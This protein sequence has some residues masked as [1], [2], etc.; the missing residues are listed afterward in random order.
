M[1]IAGIRSNRGDGYQTLVAFGWV[2]T[3]LSDP[4]YEWIEIDSVSLLVDDVVVGKTDGTL[5]CCQCKKNQIDFKDWTIA[6]LEDEIDKAAKL[7]STNKNAEVRFYSRSP[8]GAL[9]KLREYST[10][11]PDAISYRSSLS[12]KQKKIDS[13]LATKLATQASHLSTYDFLRRTFF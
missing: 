6:D 5:I 9:R 12:E 10:T 2:L 8:F 1:S 3:I 7:L 4:D 13:V 11:Q